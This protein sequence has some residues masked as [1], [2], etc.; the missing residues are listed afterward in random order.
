MDAKRQLVGILILLCGAGIFTGD[1]VVSGKSW[2]ATS[3]SHTQFL[4]DRIGPFAPESIGS[5][6][7]KGLD[8]L[9]TQLSEESDKKAMQ[10]L[11]DL[12]AEMEARH[13]REK[14][15]AV[16]QDLAILIEFLKDNIAETHV[17]EGLLL[18]YVDPVELVF[19]GLQ[20]LLDDQVDESRRPAA[21][22]RLRRYSGLEPGWTPILKQAEERLR[23]SF[24]KS[25]L[26]GPYRGEVELDLKIAPRYIAGIASLL[27]KYK[28]TNG[29]AVLSAFENQFETW[30]AFVRQEI[31]PRS[32]ADFRLPPELYRLKLKQNGIDMPLEELISRSQAA[33]REIQNEMRTIAGLVAEKRG[34]QTRDYRQV[35]RELKREQLKPE[36]AVARY[37]ERIDFMARLAREE[38]IVTFPGRNLIIRMATE[39]ESSTEPGPHMNPPPLLDNKG[40]MGEFVIGLGRS[41]G[42]QVDDFTHEAATWTLAAHEGRPGHELQI[43]RAVENGVSKARA[44]FGL[45]TATTDGWALYIEAE[46]KPYLPLEGQLFSLQFRLLRAARG[47][48]DPGLQSG[49]ISPAGALQ[50]LTRDVA[51]SAPLA[52]MELERYMDRLPGQAP[53]Y[54][55]GY[56]RMMELR[57]EVER[58]LGEKF[59]QLK[60]H[61]FL[62]KLGPLP[63]VLVRK[64]LLEDF[65]PEFLKKEAQ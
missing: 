46:M 63:I 21:L 59:D 7:G 31:L 38:K 40:E 58:R 43:T 37:R 17:T 11:V 27:E 25:G 53:A 18:P 48:L 1:D 47:F 20:F 64:A 42:P 13:G 19:F 62:M 24:K 2:V 32:R 6:G 23:G 55:C 8:E 33:F 30:K 9:I 22:V 34:W 35:I 57:A 16:R 12:L 15:A 10:T 56:T 65:V 61:D 28:F 14:H 54:F 44:L 3:D 26:L 52:K 45:N 51:I 41:D 39:A 36:V 4:L 50:V 49:D 5:A 60:Y 29:R